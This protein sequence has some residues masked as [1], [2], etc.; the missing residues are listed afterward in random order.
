LTV[1]QAANELGLVIGKDISIVGF[2][3]SPKS[4]ELY[5]PKL[6]TVDSRLTTWSHK[7]VTS[8]I[9]RLNSNVPLTNQTIYTP[10][11]IIHGDSVKL[12]KN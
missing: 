2:D 3:N 11:R 6:T 7:I 10:T 1:Y 12:I 4:G 5:K 8:L 9:S